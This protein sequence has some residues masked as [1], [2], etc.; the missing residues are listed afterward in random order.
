MIAHLTI[1]LILTIPVFD[2]DKV[3]LRRSLPLKMWLPFGNEESYYWYYYTFQAFH[4]VS[5]ANMSL[6]N[7]IFFTTYLLRA[8]H[9]FDVLKNR[10]QILSDIKKLSNSYESRLKM[11]IRIISNIVK[12]HKLVFK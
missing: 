5:S 12:H 9:Q 1:L 4:F 8:S 7:D 3:T 2:I 11:E 6:G 10:I